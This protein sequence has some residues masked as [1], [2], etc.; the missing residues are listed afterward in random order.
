M[1]CKRSECGSK[2]NYD[3]DFLRDLRQPEY[4][5]VLSLVFTIPAHP[6]ARERFP[7]T[8]GTGTAYFCL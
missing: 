2:A 4:I 8:S 3:R 1:P 5:H 6:Y 7:A